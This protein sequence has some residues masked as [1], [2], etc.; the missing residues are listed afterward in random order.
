MMI[1]IMIIAT[2]ISCISTRKSVTSLTLKLTV[3]GSANKIE[4]ELD[5]GGWILSRSMD[6]PFRH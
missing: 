6:F 5:S 4:M 3:V 2:S 1:K